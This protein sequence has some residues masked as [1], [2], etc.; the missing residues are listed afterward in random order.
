MNTDE[1][2]LEA[3]VTAHRPLTSRG[4]VRFHPAF[5]DL[6]AAGREELFARTWQQRA[7]EQALAPRGLATTANAVLARR[8]Q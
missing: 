3:A 1:P 4:E 5:H 6:D 7:M 8:Q 2:L